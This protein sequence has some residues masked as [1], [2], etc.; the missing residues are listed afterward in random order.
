MRTAALFLV[1]VC[2]LPVEASAQPVKRYPLQQ[3]VTEAGCRTELP[4]SLARRTIAEHASLND[5]GACV[6]AFFESLTNEDLPLEVIRTSSSANGIAWQ[7]AAIPLKNSDHGRVF[8]IDAER[9]HLLISL[10]YS[11]D[12]F[13]IPI[14][15][16]DL[17]YVATIYGAYKRTW[18]S[19]L[20]QYDM[21]QPHFGPHS[22]Q[23][24]V[25]DPVHRVSREIYPPDPCN[26]P[27][28]DYVRRRQQEAVRPTAGEGDCWTESEPIGGMQFDWRINNVAFAVE[29][30]ALGSRPPGWTDEDVVRLMVTCDGLSA[31]DT[32]QCRETPL[33]SWEALHPALDT[34]ELVKI[35]ASD[36]KRVRQ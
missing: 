9:G 24:G 30:Q 31:I 8:S 29:L 26:G 22:V 16:D 5:G 35:A 17:K 14:L 33:A 36:P 21:H 34:F 20:I 13:A 3:A 28:A 7:Y 2:A 32:I 10:H 18:P 25:F 1:M 15:T 19:G 6:I 27:R 23:I 4:P 11:I 12:D